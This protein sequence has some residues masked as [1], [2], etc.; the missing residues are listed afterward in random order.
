MWGKQVWF[1]CVNVSEDCRY[2]VT[3]CACVC[4]SMS[5]VLARCVYVRHT[6]TS[7]TLTWQCVSHLSPLQPGAQVQWPSSALQAPPF[8]HRQ[9]RLQPRPHVPLGQLME[10]STPCQPA[11][12]RGVRGMSQLSNVLLQNFPTLFCPSLWDLIMSHCYRKSIF[13]WQVLSNYR[14]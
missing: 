11:G 7:K 14:Q 5:S 4:V 10:Q 2:T 9:V 13:V 3:A 6:S 12:E 8:P 1:V